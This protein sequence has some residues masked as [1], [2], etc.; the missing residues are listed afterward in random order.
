MNCLG[1]ILMPVVELTKELLAC[2]SITPKEAGCHPILAERLK[3]LGFHFESLPF[4]DV[5]NF[6][7]RRGTEGPLLVFAGHTDVVPTGPETAWT[8]PPFKPTERAGFL[9][10][11]GVVDMKGGLAAMVVAVERFLKNNPEPKGSIAFLITSDEEGASINGTRKVIEVLKERGVK[12]AYCII[13]EPGSEELLGDQI[14]V[15][16]RGSLH[17]KLMI[18]GKQGHIAY[19]VPGQNPIHNCLAVLQ[20]LTTTAWDQ[21]NAFFPPTT[22]QISNIHSGTGAL[23]VVPGEVEVRFNF[24]FSTAVTAAHLQEEVERILEEHQVNYDLSWDLSG[25]P[26]L[27]KQG[28]LIDAAKAAIYEVTG[29]YPKLSTGGGTSD[30]R[31]I[32][33][34]G[35][36]VI[37]LGL[38]HATAHQI[39][40]CASIEELQ[41]L[42]HIYEAILLQLM[43]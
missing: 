5:D 33:P 42:P 10:G 39:D 38:S 29:A 8:S 3:K 41:K 26:F 32:A 40:E 43:K 16:R 17:G 37:E 20:K 13:G 23:N 21:G 25:E 19:P 1:N 24:R 18:Q 15:G 4:G 28:K 6:W 22:F 12:I 36:E 30:G 11:R 2:P 34:T 7:A 35:A 9:Y 14:R 27:T 31:F